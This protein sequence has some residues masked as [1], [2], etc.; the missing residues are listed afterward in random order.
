MTGKVPSYAN[1]I[2]LRHFLLLSAGLGLALFPSGIFQI[3][4]QAL[5]NNLLRQSLLSHLSYIILFL[6]GEAEV[7]VEVYLT[8][9]KMHRL[10]GGSVPGWRLILEIELRWERGLPGQGEDLGLC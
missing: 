4:H 6:G 10:R 5:P 1:H 9:A 8:P 7:P 2:A 3:D